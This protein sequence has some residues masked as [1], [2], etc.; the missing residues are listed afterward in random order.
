MNEP[1]R[2]PNRME[3]VRFGRRFLLLTLRRDYV[4]MSVK[5]YGAE[6][7]RMAAEIIAVARE[8]C[9]EARLIGRRHEGAAN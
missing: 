6:D 1:Y 9:P 5:I 3:N 4:M 7:A 2:R 8:A